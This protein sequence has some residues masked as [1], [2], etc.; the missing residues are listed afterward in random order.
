MTLFGKAF[1]RNV[2]IFGVVAACAFATPAFAAAICDPS[3]GGSG[4]SSGPATPPT[5]VLGGPYTIANDLS[6]GNN[7]FI[8]DASGSYSSVGRSFVLTSNDGFV[9]VGNVFTV[10]QDFYHLSGTL[11][12]H[13]TADDTSNDVSHAATSVTFAPGVSNTVSGVPEPATWAMLLI[14]L[15][16]IGL[17]MR[18]KHALSTPLGFQASVAE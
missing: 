6:G 1:M 2:W 18:R 9:G 15:G 4:S 3:C 14:G 17:A 10:P 8:I 13:F 12:L 11:S 16:G 5:I 7:S